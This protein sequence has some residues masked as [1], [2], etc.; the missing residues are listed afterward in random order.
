VQSANNPFAKC[1]AANFVRDGSSFQ[2]DIVCPGRGAA[3]AHATYTLSADTF[4]GFVA[5]V[6]GAKNMT[7]TE[8]QRGRRIGDC[9]PEVLG[10]AVTVLSPR[11]QTGGTV[12]AHLR[13]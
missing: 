12:G 3:K 7:M 5:M 1:T 13:R 11:S 10:S 2:Y 9:G 4:S 8:V 6:M